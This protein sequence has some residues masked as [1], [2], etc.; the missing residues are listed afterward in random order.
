MKPHFMT[1]LRVELIDN[2]NSGTWRL[3]EPLQYWSPQWGLLIVPDGFETDFASVPRAPL[4]YWLTGNTAH[5]PAVLHDWL[6]RDKIIPR[7]DADNVFKEAMHSIGV[8]VWRVHSMW[9]AVRAYSTTVA[10]WFEC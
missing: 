3:L 8:P 7:R 1:P 2:S 4:A 6:C 9:L 10:R 5:A